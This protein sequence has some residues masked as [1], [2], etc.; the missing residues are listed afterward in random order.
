M[1]NP[2]SLS[3]TQNAVPIAI[4]NFRAS[5]TVDCTTAPDETMLADNT[6]QEGFQN[7]V[8]SASPPNTDQDELAYS[9]QSASDK[10]SR[11]RDVDRCL[12]LDCYVSKGYSIR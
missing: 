7:P 3:A 11:V 4:K 10:E 1:N 6:W 9:I 2:L 8:P 5:N 12:C